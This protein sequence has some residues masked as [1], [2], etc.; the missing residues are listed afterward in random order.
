MTF[1]E[2]SATALPRNFGADNRTPNSAFRTQIWLPSVNDWF[3][4]AIATSEFRL[5]QNPPLKTDRQEKGQ[6]R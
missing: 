5:W 1:L 4:D 6:E 3:E 2:G